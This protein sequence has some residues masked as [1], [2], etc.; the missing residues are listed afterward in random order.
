MKRLVGTTASLKTGNPKHPGTDLGA[1][2]DE[3]SFNKI[4]RYIEIG[5]KESELA[6]EGV[7]DATDG[8]F[9]GPVIFANVKPKSVVAQEEI[10]GPVLAI[11]RAKDFSEALSI[12]NDS[13]YHLTGGIY[14]RTDEN[15]S[16]AKK[17]FSVGNLY[18]NRNITGAI[19]GRQPFG[20]FGA[21]GT[22]PKAGGPDYLLP[23]MEARHIAE[24]LMRRGFSTE[25]KN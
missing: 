6:Y 5:K 2:I 18:I 14:S 13:C 10:F 25:L 17:F 12:A 3:K 15:I 1:V 20:G 22:G 16:L 7:I 11:I 8:W 9:V 24:N 21:S 19:V 23:L 4:R